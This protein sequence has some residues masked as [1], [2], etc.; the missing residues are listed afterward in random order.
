MRSKFYIYMKFEKSCHS[1]KVGTQKVWAWPVCFCNKE[2]KTHFLSEI[3]AVISCVNML[4]INTFK[5]H[6]P[7]GLVCN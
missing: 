3:S 6:F 2:Q 7:H 5:I 1:A 4:V